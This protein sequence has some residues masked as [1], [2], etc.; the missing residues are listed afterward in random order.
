MALS[1]NKAWNLIFQEQEVIKHVNSQWYFDLKANTIKELT[2]NEPRLMTKIDFIHSLPE[3]MEVNKLSILAIENWL[4]RISKASPYINIWDRKNPEKIIIPPEWY[5]SLDPFDIT[6]ES[7]ALDVAHIWG[8]LYDVF[9]EETDLTI[10]WRLRKWANFN[11][12]LD[13]VNYPINW[14]QIEV[15]WWYEWKRNLNIV[16]AKIWAV[17]NIN[18][19][20]LL[21]PTLAWKNIIWNQK[22]INTY[23]FIYDNPY[24]RFIPFIQNGSNWFADIAN[25][26]VFRFKSKDTYNL[27]NIRIQEYP[28][29]DFS[30][31]FPQA[32]NFD[33]VLIM[34]RILSQKWWEVTKTELKVLMEDYDLSERQIDYYSNCLKLFKLID[35]TKQGILLNARWKDIASIKVKEQAFELAK[36]IFSEPVFNKTLNKW[37]DSISDTDFKKHWKVMTWAT[38]L[39]RKQTLKKWVNWFKDMFKI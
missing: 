3:I 19:R 13:G 8:I 9:W 12:L 31:P 32:D 25:E 16:E 33:K 39:R 36:V 29:L 7:M 35:F 28:E 15:D 4:Y 1:K 14:V 23:I 30:A 11:F 2:W 34:L 18:L 37:I 20:Q 38:V 26:K 21:Y 10:R 22:K 27:E 5:L 6:S 24:F 17:W